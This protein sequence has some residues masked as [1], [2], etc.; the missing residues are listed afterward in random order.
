MEKNKKRM[1]QEEFN[2]K[3]RRLQKQPFKS[4]FN[5]NRTEVDELKKRVKILEDKLRKK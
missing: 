4:F 2:E 5:N 1:T 3:Q